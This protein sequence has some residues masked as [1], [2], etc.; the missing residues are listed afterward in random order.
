MKKLKKVLRLLR[1][2]FFIVLAAVG[3]G[4]SGGAPIPHFS[5]KEDTIEVND[6]NESS[7]DETNIKYLDREQNN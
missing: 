6:E 5:R 4:L 1:L 7:D 3:M 2:I